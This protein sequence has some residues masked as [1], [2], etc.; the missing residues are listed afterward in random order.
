MKRL[1]FVLGGLVL[2][3]ALL[4]LTPLGTTAFG[5]FAKSIAGLAQDRFT[6]EVTIT[7]THASGNDKYTI[8]VQSNAATVALKVYTIHLYFDDVL[9]AQTQT[10]TWTALEIPGTVKKIT[11][12]G[13]NTSSVLIIEP[14]IR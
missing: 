6:G 3:F 4:F 13:L 1:L 8:W 14:E 10:V 5:F 2:V 7:D 11:F 12:T 9:Q